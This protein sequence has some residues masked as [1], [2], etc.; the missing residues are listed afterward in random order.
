MI[1]WIQF[2]LITLAAYLLLLTMV[3]CLSLSKL[4]KNTFD[5]FINK[6]TIQDPDSETSEEDKLKQK[7]AKE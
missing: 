4:R 3:S 2:M 1:S 6:K 5:Y 7:K